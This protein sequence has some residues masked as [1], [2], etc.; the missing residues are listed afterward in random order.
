MQFLTDSGPDEFEINHLI[1]AGWTGRDAAAVQHHID[2]LS[3]LGVAPPS[4]VPL[5]Y[6]AANTLVTTAPDIQVL[7]DATS[8]EAEPM[9]IMRAGKLWLGLGS[10][11]TDRQLEATSVAASK[12]ACQKPCA[13]E[14][15]DF[16]TVSDHL[17]QITIRSWIY[18]DDGWCLYQD[19]TLGQ[20]LPLTQLLKNSDMADQSAMLCGTFSAIG[21]VRG[22]SKFRATMYDP[23]PKREIGFEYGTI[24][25][26]TIS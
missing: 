9:L 22:A 10:D 16:D 26:P 8:G 23:I 4:Q 19:G 20:I 7:G 17:D 1:I 14:L 18:E 5:F 3:A 6:R 13:A 11:H 24:C 2:E 25:L 21:G 12:Q 15:W